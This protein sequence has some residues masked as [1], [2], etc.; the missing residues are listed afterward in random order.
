MIGLSGCFEPYD[1]TKVTNGVIIYQ[2]YDAVNN[3][4]KIVFRGETNIRLKGEHEFDLNREIT[5]VHE[6]R[7]ATTLISY[8]Y[9]E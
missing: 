3:E 7:Y 2:S 9:K 1:L 6:G 8:E 4:T 5:I